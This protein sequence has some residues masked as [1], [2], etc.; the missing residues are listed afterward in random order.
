MLHPPK[1]TPFHFESMLPALFQVESSEVS[2]ADSPSNNPTFAL[3]QEFRTGPEGVSG[4]TH[5]VA[6]YRGLGSQEI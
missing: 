2:H 6:L 5:I 1:C 3:R 4:L